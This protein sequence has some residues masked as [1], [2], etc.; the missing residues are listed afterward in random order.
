MERPSQWAARSND[1]KVCDEVRLGED[2]R[3]DVVDDLL[4]KQDVTGWVALLINLQQASTQ[5]AST[6]SILDQREN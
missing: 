3:G 2:I 6:E 5:R 1:L 4:I